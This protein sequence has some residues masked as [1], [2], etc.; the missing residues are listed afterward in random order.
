MINQVSN[1]NIKNPTVELILNLNKYK[2][3]IT[4]EIV[5]GKKLKFN[6]INADKF[7][8]LLDSNNILNDNLSYLNILKYNF[9]EI[10]DQLVNYFPD[11]KIN[12]FTNSPCVSECQIKQEEFTYKYDIYLV[13]SKDKKIYEYGFDF[14]S[15]LNDIP[16]NKYSDSKTLLDNYEY[17]VKKDINSNLDIK[18]YLNENLFKLLTTICA[19]KKDEYQLAE[20]IFVKSN[21]NIISTKQILKE[22]GYFLRIIE[23]KKNNLIDLEDLFDNLML[24]NNE[25]NEQINKKQFLNIIKNICSNK[26][27]NFSIKQKNISYEIFV[28]LLMNINSIYNSQ[29]LEQY[30]DIYIKALELLMNSLKII[31]DM[32]E[33][34]NIKKKF[35]FDYINNFIMFHLHEYQNKKIINNIYINELNKKKIL[36]ENLSNNITEYYDKNKH[37]FDKLD[38]IKNDFDLAYD[39]IFYY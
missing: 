24:E 10:I 34:I 27:I 15:D 4:E 28:I 35:T 29:V 39:I 30:K 38:K 37:D 33:E 7:I 8:E 36:L 6:Y 21:N 26:N 14:I 22:L 1:Q 11:I 18:Y 31:T 3:N 23:W 5:Y 13:L 2:K 32:V 12:K 20:V 25:T 17:F 9:N 16:Q 19:I